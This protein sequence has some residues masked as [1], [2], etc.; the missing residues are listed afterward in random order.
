M[1]ISDLGKLKNFQAA[2]AKA[3]EDL[4]KMDPE[5]VALNARVDYVQKTDSFIVP[6]LGKEYRL[7]R[8]AGR[9]HHPPLPDEHILGS[10]TVLLLH[11]LIGSKQRMLRNKLIS[12]RELPNGMVFYNA[13]RNL[14][15]DPI[16]H[17]FGN[18][19]KGFEERGLKLGGHRVNYGE[20]SFEFSIFPR[21]PVTYILW[22]GDDEIPASANILFDLSALEHLHTEDLA[23]VGEVITHQLVHRD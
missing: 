14:A 19:I 11:Y 5:Q 6:V 13:F 12:Y 4:S 23:E 3:S 17:N 1:I 21:V 15:I 9:I 20:I 7:E 2:I 16:A 10:M 8:A 22:T 18:D